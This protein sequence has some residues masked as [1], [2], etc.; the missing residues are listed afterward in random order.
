MARVA[1]GKLNQEK[2]GIHLDSGA[3]HGAEKSC[4]SDADGV[5]KRI[6]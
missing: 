6:K 3:L 1:Q 4:R 5:G 2:M